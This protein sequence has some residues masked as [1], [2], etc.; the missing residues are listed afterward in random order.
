MGNAPAG[1]ALDGSDS[2]D[3]DPPDELI[4]TWTQIDGPPVD[5]NEPASATPYFEC[6][7]AG[8]YTFELVVSDGFV[9]SEADR[10][11]L[12]AS[13]FTLN[14][15]SSV[16]I[17]RDMEQYYVPA[18]SGTGIV[19][20]LR[21]EEYDWQICW[22]D[23][24]T[25]EVQIFDGGAVE[26]KPQVDGDLIVWAAG[27]GYYYQPSVTSVYLA[28][29]VTGEQTRLERGSGRQSCGYP[30]ISGNK[31]VWLRHHDVDTDDEDSYDNSPYDVCGADLSD[32]SN[33]VYFTVAEATGHG[34]PYPHEDYYS[35]NEG[36]VDVC[37]DIVVWESDGDIYGA[38][39]SDLENITVFAICTAPERQYDP[40]ISGDLV[41]WTDE[42]NDIGDIYAADISD[43]NNVRE[44]PVWV[45]PGWQAQPD[46]DGALIICCN[47]G[48][49]TGYFQTCCVSREYGLVE[50]V[51]PDRPYGSNPDVDGG[52]IT[53]EYNGQANRMTLDFGYGLTAG[54]VENQTTGWRYDYLQHAIAAAE[55][56]DVIVA[57][58]GT[59]REKLRVGGKNI[60]VTS[61][62]PEDATVRGATVLTGEGPLV[63][64]DDDATTDDCFFTGFTVTGGSFGIVCNGA[65]PTISHCDL[66]GNR[67]AGIKLWGE[68]EPTVSYCEINGNGIGVEMWAQTGTRYVL[69]NG[70][71]LRNCVITG[72]RSYGVLGGEPTVSNCTVADNLGY[73]LWCSS[74]ALDN[75]IVYFNN[76]GGENVAGRKSLTVTYSDVQGGA[77]GAGNIDGDPLFVAR[78]GWTEAGW[79]PGDYHLQSQGWSW[80]SLQGD[81][82]WDEATS[83][84]IDAGNPSATLGDEP[85]CET[86]DP[87]SERATNSRLNMGAYGGTSEA[88]LA[89]R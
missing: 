32:R 51:L 31:V 26:A 75:S 72:N 20:L 48:N 21:D 3:A 36:Y 18:V 55:D 84:C 8:V 66:S 85:P 27:S 1:S 12:E 69:D 35:I 45:E 46:V 83:P 86:G 76:G 56:G 15:E 5:L 73:G 87:L 49:D 81:W 57:E 11:K 28:D 22:I 14:V 74:L 44:F 40:V 58:P 33:P 89:P 70:G 39:L 67:D 63:I 37:G 38:D 80:D 64:F 4:Y 78:G 24:E 30:M 68:S 59:Y 2:S 13:P 43:R 82:S 34:R 42:R 7:E 25:G 60:T 50:F 19:S 6:Q 9:D 47:G 10:V 52:T 79:V 17:D 71:T 61:T 29:L 23:A 53:W 41:V 62:D 54:P 65:S 77:S 16:V 88:S